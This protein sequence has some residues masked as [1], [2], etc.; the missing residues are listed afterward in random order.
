MKAVLVDAGPLVAYYNAGDAWHHPIREFLESFTGQLFTTSPVMTEA[1]YLLQ[2]SYK[3]QNE[4]LIDVSRGLYQVVDLL[5]QDFSK[6]AELN[7]KYSDLPADFADLSLIVISERLQ[8]QEIVTL[9][10]DFEVYRQ[11]GRKRFKRVFPARK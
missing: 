1:L 2:S 9:D 10:S 8:V 3:V 6:V 7:S 4:L 5:P 11:F